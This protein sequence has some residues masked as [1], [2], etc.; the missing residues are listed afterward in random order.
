MLGQK[1]NLSKFKKTE[2]KHLLQPQR[3]GIRHQLQEKKLQ[4]TKAQ[5]Q[6][7]SQAKSVKHLQKS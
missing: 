2:I 6:M 3:Y 5:D 1:A 7:A 4:K